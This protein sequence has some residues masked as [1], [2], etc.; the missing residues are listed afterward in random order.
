M[1]KLKGC[2]VLNQLV[3]SFFYETILV[4]AM[5]LVDCNGTAHS[6]FSVLLGSHLIARAARSTNFQNKASGAHSRARADS[7]IPCA[8]DQGETRRGVSGSTSG[9]HPRAHRRKVF[10][11]L[12]GTCL[13]RL[14]FSSVR[15]CSCGERCSSAFLLRCLFCCCCDQ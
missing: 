2:E 4:F 11:C 8:T 9:A 6:C 7:G 10:A 5:C 13:R 3:L 14:F 1:T 15:K 12:L